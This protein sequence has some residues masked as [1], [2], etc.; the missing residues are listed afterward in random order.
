MGTS[1]ASSGSASHSP[2]VPT[3]LDELPA[4]APSEESTNPSDDLPGASGVELDEARTHDEGE[5]PSILP[6]PSP[7][8]FRAAR[9]NFTRFARSVG[10]DR[11]LLRRAVGDYI[12]DGTGG[13][14]GAVR[15]MGASRRAART[16]L[17]ILRDFQRTG[18]RQ[19]LHRLELRRLVGQSVRD[20]L[21]GLTDIIC[22]D[23][24]TIDAAAARL[25]WIETV[26][27]LDRLDLDSLDTLTA[28]E[29]KEIYLTYIG[30]T[31]QERLYQEV[32]VKGLRAASSAADIERIDTQFRDYI[33][34]TVRDS[35]S[36]DITE[37]SSMTD[38]EIAEIVDRT[39]LDT[40]QLFEWQ[41]ELR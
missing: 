4:T 17:G 41:A 8:R 34:R 14:L 9:G 12:R 23:G 11:Y 29:V 25:A 15:R 40:W 5:R 32:R 26:A 36:G 19:T 33:Q 35:F 20:V 2:L 7:G 31:I 6:P 22:G 38:D 39:Y 28:D 16:T 24:A 10:R 18:T 30:H 37:L 27:E 3:W 13:R 21:I 1:S